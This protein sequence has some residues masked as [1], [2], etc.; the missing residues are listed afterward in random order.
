MKKVQLLRGR[1]LIRERT[2]T[3]K[4]ML[5]LIPPL[6][7]I[8]EDLSCLHATDV[9]LT[10]FLPL[11]NRLRQAI[12]VRI[13]VVIDLDYVQSFGKERADFVEEFERLAWQRV[14]V[15]YVRESQEASR[16]LLLDINAPLDSFVSWLSLLSQYEP[17][18]DSMLV[19]HCINRLL[20]RRKPRRA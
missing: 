1:R 15:F 10:I 5:W 7:R 3:E 12:D 14:I 9:I 18:D 6:P 17:H 8:R 11:S 20:V 2:S 4:R 19:E 13:H 16:P